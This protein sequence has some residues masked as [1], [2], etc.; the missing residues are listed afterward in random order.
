MSLDGG[1]GG[2]ILQQATRL[3]NGL[4]VIS[5]PRVRILRH[6]GKRITNEKKEKRKKR[7]K[8]K[9]KKQKKEE[10]GQKETKDKTHKQK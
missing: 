7:K 1:I 6:F 8:E 3:C 9:R 5:L 4:V 10:K 2:L